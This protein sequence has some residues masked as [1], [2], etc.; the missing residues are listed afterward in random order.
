MRQNG[1]S[2]TFL[3]SL[4]LFFVESRLKKR[5]TD[6]LYSSASHFC[7]KTWRC[8]VRFCCERHIG[9]RRTNEERERGGRGGMQERN[10]SNRNSDS[11][12]GLTFSFKRKIYVRAL[13]GLAYLSWGVAG[14]RFV[15]VL[16]WRTLLNV[17]GRLPAWGS[18]CRKREK[19]RKDRF[20]LKG[21]NASLSLLT[22]ERNFNTKRLSSDQKF[23]S[24]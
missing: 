10:Y 16:A 7:S 24:F 13:N 19:E 5:L 14:A 21:T 15:A 11:Q 17:P 3:P 8:K 9:L 6:F 1:Q 18:F 12:R 4:A 23:P 2:Q 20:R 22:N